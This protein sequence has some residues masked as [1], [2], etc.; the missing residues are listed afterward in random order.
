[1]KKALLTLLFAVVSMGAFAQFEQN[2]KY[3]STSLT[4]LNLSYN[5]ATDFHLGLQATGGYFIQDGWMILGQLGYDHMK[6]HNDFT[7]GAASRYY[8]EQNG[9]YLNL[10]AKYQYMGPGINNVYLTPEV[11]YC[12][13]VNH[14]LSIEPAVYYDLCV[15]NFSDYST[16]GLKVGFGFYF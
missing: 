15:N 12:F 3:I 16:I 1:M 2:T 7:L 11:G 9:L 13:Y 8:M 10:G 4:G 5:K 14:H 6:G